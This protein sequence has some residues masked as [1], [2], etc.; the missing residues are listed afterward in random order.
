MPRVADNR[1]RQRDPLLLRH[2]TA[3]R[4][5][6]RASSRTWSG[7][8]SMNRAHRLGAPLRRSRRRWRRA[9][10][11]AM[12]SR[13]GGVEQEA[14]LADQRDLVPPG[15]TS[16]SRNER[17]SVGSLRG[18]IVEAQN[19]LDDRG[20]S[21]ARRT[22]DRGRL[23]GWNRERCVGERRF[24]VVVVPERHAIEDDAVVEA[25]CM[26][27]PVLSRSSLGASSTDRTSSTDDASAVS[28]TRDD[29]KSLTRGCSR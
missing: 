6:A 23:A 4:R 11:Y 1:A 18:R 12:L 19:Q 8:R 5:D 21:A 28:L 22:D 27:G 25:G 17:P 26:L 29:S 14:V 10:P 7:S 24:L 15:R 2:R 13:T 20:L 9:R 16:K 3:G